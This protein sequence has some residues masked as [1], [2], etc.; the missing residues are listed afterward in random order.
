MDNIRKY[1][2]ENR[3]S[4][5]TDIPD[6]ENWARL[7]RKFSEMG[8]TRRVRVRRLISLGVA[9]SLLLAAAGFALW[10]MN[11]TPNRRMPVQ[12][13]VVT[14][15]PAI[16]QA[17]AV[18]NVYSPVVL[19]E[20]KDLSKTSFYGPNRNDFKV[21]SF[22]WKSL[23]ANEKAIEQN[24]R[25]VGPNSRSIQQLT[26]NYELKIRLLRQ[27]SVEINKVR[28]LL[29]PADTLVKVPS[30]SI[31]RIKTSNYEKE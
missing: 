14:A 11:G 6:E 30:L 17:E 10:K 22:Q 24:M 5:D 21:F 1:L 31:L 16:P 25:S 20:L 13:A 26:D 9:A 29:P 19:R 12:R 8:R 27:F 2:S 15:A 4:F 3:S 23:E 28:N 7:S 18:A